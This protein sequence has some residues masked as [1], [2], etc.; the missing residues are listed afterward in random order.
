MSPR[1]LAIL[2]AIVIFIVAGMVL[3]LK[4]A[5][6]VGAS[7]REA[8]IEGKAAKPPPKKPQ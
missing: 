6:D 5:S 2:A 4:R 8:A 7:K 3:S 1:I